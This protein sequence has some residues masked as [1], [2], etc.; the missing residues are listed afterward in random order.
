[1]SH[2]LAGVRRELT[3]TTAQAR[4]LV[5]EIETS[6]LLDVASRREPALARVLGAPVSNQGAQQ[7]ALA[8]LAP[9]LDPAVASS[10][11]RFRDLSARWYAAR[12]RAG[13]AAVAGHPGEGAA[14]RAGTVSADEAAGLAEVLA[15]AKQLDAALAGREAQERARLRSL[16][17]LDV[18][19][20]AVLVPVLLGVVLAVYGVGRRMAALAH[21]A[22]RNRLAL[23]RASDQKVALLRGLTHDL[24]NTLWAVTGFAALLRDEI[25]GPLTPPQRDHVTRIG[26]LVDQAITVVSDTLEIARAD[27][28]T[29]PVSRQWVDLLALLAECASDYRAKADAAG[30]ILAAE[31]SPGLPAVETDPSHVTKIVG[32]LLSNAIKYT[33]GGGRV[34]LRAAARSAPRD[35]VPGPWIAVEVADTGPGVPAAFRQRIFDEF[36]R[37]PNASAVAPGT[38]VGLA[39]SRRVA[40]ALGGEITMD[41][42]DGRGAICTLWLPGPGGTARHAARR[43]S[44]AANAGH[45]H[46]QATA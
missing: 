33:P 38:G 45:G 37:M 15:A 18:L 42:E 13:L 39:M 7:E 34:W 16:E 9:S 29:L 30:L 19:L 11:R 43:T 23:V 21:E 31:F 44:S 27:A 46:R 20:P 5:H 2:R 40:R 41:G 25:V 22:E 12:E 32:N 1:V 8:S 3:G 17:A 28:G 26:R 10:V 35:L 14:P 36:F 4:G 24:K 6:L